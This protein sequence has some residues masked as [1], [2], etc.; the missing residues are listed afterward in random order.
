MI[1]V[2][3]PA[4]VGTPC[5]TLSAV[6]QGHAHELPA[7]AGLDAVVEQ[8]AAGQVVYLTRDGEPVA[9]VVS[10]QAAA[11]VERQAQ[12]DAVLGEI[13]AHAGAPTLDHYRQVYASLGLAW[14][15]DDEVR[16]L[17]P[18]SA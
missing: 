7:D 4:L 12:A 17:Y 11:M 3:R 5:P 2:P 15:G 1:F 10:A 6:G 14:P 9:A 16:R 8:A 13:V 18:V